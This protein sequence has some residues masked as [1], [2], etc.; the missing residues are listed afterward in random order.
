MPPSASTAWATTSSADLKAE[1]ELTRANTMRALRLMLVSDN[2]VGVRDAARQWM[3]ETAAEPSML[4]VFLMANIDEIQTAM[5]SWNQQLADFSAKRLSAEGKGDVPAFS[6][7]NSHVEQAD[8]MLENLKD[9]FRLQ[10]PLSGTT[11]WAALA[12]FLMMMVP[13]WVQRRN[14]KSTYRLF[15]HEGAT[16][17]DRLFNRGSGKQ[18][19]VR[20]FQSEEHDYQRHVRKF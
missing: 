12:L 4:N 13:W 2:Y 10:Q 16:P 11:P 9:E 6:N 17:L 5:Q 3:D 20:T 18:N 8:V 15:G 14:T 19:R 1:R 7:R